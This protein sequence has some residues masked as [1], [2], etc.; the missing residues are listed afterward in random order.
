MLNRVQHDNGEEF[1]VTLTL[2]GST[3]T[4]FQG[5]M[6]IDTSVFD[7]GLSKTI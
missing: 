4:E 5:L 7:Y 3:R 6:K 2:S 1:S